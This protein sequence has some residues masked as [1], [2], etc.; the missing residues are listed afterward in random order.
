MD[1]KSFDLLHRYIEQYKWAGLLVEP[2]PHEFQKLKANYRSHDNLLFENSAIR[3]Y[4]GIGE[5]FCVHVDQPETARGL[6]TFFPN[7]NNV[8]KY[9]AD[10]V[11]TITVQC[12]TPEELLK[13]HHIKKVGLLAID[14]EGCDAE[15]ISVWDFDKLRPMVVIYESQNLSSEEASSTRNLLTALGYELKQLQF[16]VLAW[17]FPQLLML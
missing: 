5:M 15:I 17:R 3:E 12:I 4:S 7:K 14:A 2:I 8:H 1:G 10:F 6:S 11:Q 13:K 16:D 9:N